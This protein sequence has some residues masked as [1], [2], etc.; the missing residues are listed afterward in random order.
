MIIVII[1]MIAMVINTL[2]EAAT[3]MELTE[4][5]VTSILMEVDIS[6]VRT[7][8]KDIGILMAQAII[9][10]QMEVMVTYIPTVAVTIMD[11]MGLH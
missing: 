9:A 8:V 11:R 2:M 10:E 6:R 3:I 4:A 1:M 7:V 5:K